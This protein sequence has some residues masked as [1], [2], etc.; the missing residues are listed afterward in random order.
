VCLKRKKRCGKSEP[1]RGAG[2][3]R[4]GAAPWR[5]AGLLRGIALCLI[6]CA[7]PAIRPQTPISI[8]N[9]GP[10]R[11]IAAHGRRAAIFGFAG[12]S[13]EIWGYPFQI[14]VG[15]AS[16]GSFA[17]KG[18]ELSIEA[19]VRAGGDSTLI[20]ETPWRV[21]AVEGGTASALAPTRTEI[22]IVPAAA[23]A[24]AEKYVTTTV[25][26]RFQQP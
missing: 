26:V 23:P 4:K 12:R 18:M 22:Q 13:L 7:A 20:V 10:Y 5:R 24:G 3:R 8:A 21:T 2:E 9:T 19:D 6:A 1:L 11:F 16:P 25:R 17:L 14:C 15:C